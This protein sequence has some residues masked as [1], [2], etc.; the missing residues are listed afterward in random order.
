MLG[1]RPG[2]KGGAAETAKQPVTNSHIFSKAPNA[3][4]NTWKAAEVVTDANGNIYY[5]GF[6]RARDNDSIDFG[7]GAFQNTNGSLVDA[8]LIKFDKHGTCQWQKTFQDNTSSLSKLRKGFMADDL[9]LSSTGNPIL[10]YRVISDDP[11]VNYT[12][13]YPGIAEYSQSG[14]LK[15]KDV[16]KQKPAVNSQFI[17]QAAGASSDRLFVAGWTDHQASF[18]GNFVGSGNMVMAWGPLQNGTRSEK[19]MRRFGDIDAEVTDLAVSPDGTATFVGNYSDAF[20]YLDGSSAPLAGNGSMF[21]QS[22]TQDGSIL[23]QWGSHSTG[24]TAWDRESISA[25]DFGPDGALYLGGIFRGYLNYRLDLGGGRSNS[26]MPAL[27]NSDENNDYFVLKYE[28]ISQLPR[29][30]TAGSLLDW[31]ISGMYTINQQGTEVALRNEKL[32][33]LDASVN[34][35]AISGQACNYNVKECFQTDGFMHI[36]Q[37]GNMPASGQ[38]Y[39][40]LT[41]RLLTSQGEGAIGWN[42]AVDPVNENVVW[43][44][45]NSQDQY[46]SLGGGTLPGTDYFI[47]SYGVSP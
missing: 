25:V 38:N 8:F 45:Y 41:R 15:W 29:K 19:W 36:F 44:G 7:C 37:R 40:K 33:D 1:D 23:Q 28:G 20:D 32:R 17:L 14:T 11:G 39:Q 16:R 18:A 35:V 2:F 47:A 5:A 13:T 12:N 26:Y 9:T 34:W 4:N 27:P 43:N 22:V 30:K 10:V 24:P 46:S 42:I 6:L 21:I 31:H 3:K